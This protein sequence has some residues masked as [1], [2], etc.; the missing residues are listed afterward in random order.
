MNALELEVGTRVVVISGALA[1]LEAIVEMTDGPVVVL[2][3]QG[4]EGVLFVLDHNQ[5]RPID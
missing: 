4:Y 2:T 1:G 5:V 3:A